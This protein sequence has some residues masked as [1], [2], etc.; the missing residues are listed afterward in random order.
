MYRTKANAKVLYKIFQREGLS[1]NEAARK[2]GLS[3]AT[4]TKIMSGKCIAES[5]G[6]ALCDAFGVSPDEVLEI[7]EE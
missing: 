6:K 2:A 5:T 7:V 1:Q 3:T 4:M